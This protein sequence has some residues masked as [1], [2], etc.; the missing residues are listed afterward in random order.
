MDA[1]QALTRF[2]NRDSSSANNLQLYPHKRRE[3]WLWLNT[4]ACFIQR[5]SDLGFDDAGYD[6]PPLNVVWDMVPVEILSDQVEKN[7]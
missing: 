6:L 1:G 2:F 4:W 3:F 5:P 7:G